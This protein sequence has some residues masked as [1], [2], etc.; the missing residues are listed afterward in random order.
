MKEF[1]FKYKSFADKIVQY[2]II[3]LMFYVFTKY[4][5]HYVAPFVVALILALIFEPLI[6][7]LNRYLKLSRGISSI[8]VIV[9]TFAVIIFLGTGIVLKI[10]DEAK[11]LSE[12]IPQYQEQIKQTYNNLKIQAETYFY[13]VPEEIQT[14]I[15]KLFDTLLNSITALLGSGVK[16][17]SINFVSKVPSGFMFVLVTIISTFFIMKDRKEIEKFIL[18]KSPAPL[19]AAF[20]KFKAHSLGALL[21]YFKA[22]LMLMCCTFIICLIVLTVIKSPY[23]LLMATI[24]SVVDAL[25]VFGSG[26][27]LWPWAAWNL[28]SG[29]YGFAV[30]LVINY[31]IV[32]LTRQILE[33]KFVG[34]QIG[35]HPLITLFSIYVGL[36][37]FGVIGIIIGPV[38]AVLIK[39]VSS[40]EN[41]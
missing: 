41:L 32:I 5:F 6:K 31:L 10:F 27:I 20:G 19:I 24:I 8:I 29:N 34:E 23:S 11:A 18:K 12:N 22:Q 37:I 39:A 28:I 17:G 3:F 38:I 33:P 1:Y 9:G 25:P 26:F 40:T 21:G 2:F 16:T 14:T 35:I 13:L 30:G 7:L 15:S 4:I 36:Q